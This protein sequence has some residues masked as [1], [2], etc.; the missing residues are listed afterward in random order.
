[1]EQWSRV[2]VGN[3]FNKEAAQK[4]K[5]GYRPRLAPVYGENDAFEAH[6]DVLAARKDAINSSVQVYESNFVEIDLVG[7]LEEADELNELNYN[8]ESIT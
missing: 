6:G 3:R 2:A 4:K 7:E 8:M 5:G 1:V